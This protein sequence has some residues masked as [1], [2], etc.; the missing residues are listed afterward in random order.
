M[1][2]PRALRRLSKLSALAEG[3]KEPIVEA[4]SQLSN[5][6]ANVETPVRR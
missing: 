1:P 5:R 4:P 3:E 6:Y 2:L